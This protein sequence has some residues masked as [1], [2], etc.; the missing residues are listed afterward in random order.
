[1][2]TELKELKDE[3]RMLREEAERKERET[4]AKR[5]KKKSEKRPF[6]N[7]VTLEDIKGVLEETKSESISHSYAA[8][9]DRICVL[10]IYILGIRVAELKQ[11]TISQIYDYLDKKPMEIAKVKGKI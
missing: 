8:C 2:T 3:I 4:Q 7:S 6:K 9:R 1:M 11:I 10:L 5:E